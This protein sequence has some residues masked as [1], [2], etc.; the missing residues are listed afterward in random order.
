[1]V[2]SIVDID[3]KGNFEVY[4]KLEKKPGRGLTQAQTPGQ[5]YIFWKLEGDINQ[6]DSH[7]SKWKPLNPKY[8]PLYCTKVH[9]E[10]AKL[11]D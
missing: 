5:V 9:P 1:M 3:W 8:E 6:N 11:T 10:C 7:R 4:W 2:Q